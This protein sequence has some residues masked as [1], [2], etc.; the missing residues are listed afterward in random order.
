MHVANAYII[1]FL[2]LAKTG[3]IGDMILKIDIKK[4]LVQRNTIN[5]D[6]G[7]TWWEKK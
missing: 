5:H 7:L 1:L 3:D 6:K 4:Q 2:T